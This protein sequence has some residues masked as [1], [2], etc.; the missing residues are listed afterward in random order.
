MKARPK[1]KFPDR[2][3]NPGLSCD[4]RRYLPLY[5]RGLHYKQPVN[6][7]Q[8]Y[9]R[10]PNFLKWRLVQKRSSPTGNRTRVFRVTGGDTYHYTI[11][12]HT[13]SNQLMPS[14]AIDVD[15]TFKN[16]GSSK[17][18]IPWP[19]IEPGTFVWQ[20][21]ILTTILSRTTLQATS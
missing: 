8:R 17:K 7:E 9:R 12:D 5:Y 2:E 20:A 18:E 15:Q 4:R 21:E 13:T 6:A 3:S 1:K 10:G 14:N 19:G 16:E 11:E